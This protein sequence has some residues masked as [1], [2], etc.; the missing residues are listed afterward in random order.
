MTN[1]YLSTS[2]VPGTLGSPGTTVLNHTEKMS[3]LGAL[4]GT[5]VVDVPAWELYWIEGHAG[6]GLGWNNDKGMPEERGRLGNNW[7]G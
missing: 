4:D 2:F 5:G 6:Q 7:V 3:F 1:I